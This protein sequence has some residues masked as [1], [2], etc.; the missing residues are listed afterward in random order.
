MGLQAQ[1]GLDVPGGERFTRLGHLRGSEPFEAL[2]RGLGLA[3]GRPDTH[4][5]GTHSIRGCATTQSI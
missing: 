3:N 2:G 5:A 4:N 1:V